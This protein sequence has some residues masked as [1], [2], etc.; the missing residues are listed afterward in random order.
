MEVVLEVGA[1]DLRED[2]DVFVVLSAPNTFAAVNAGLAAAG[3]T[4]RDAGLASVPTQRTAVTDRDVAVKLMKMIDGLGD[5]DDVQ[6]IFTNEELLRTSLRLWRAEFGGFKAVVLGWFTT[7]SVD[8][9]L[10]CVWRAAGRR[11]TRRRTGGH[12][13]GGPQG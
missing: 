5:N 11:R 4:F 1:D 3:V 9:A 8:G 2:G 12:R 13:G 7:R 10:R 6:E